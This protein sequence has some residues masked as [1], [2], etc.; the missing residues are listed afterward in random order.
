MEENRALLSEQEEKV[1][2]TAYFALIFA[3]LF[4]SGVFGELSKIDGGQWAWLG[5]FDFTTLGGKFGRL[6]LGGG[7]LAANF[8][9]QGG[10]GSRDAFLYA[11]TLA[12]QVIFALGVVKIVEDLGALKAAQKLI[13]PILRLVMGVP[14]SCAVALVTSLQ[15]TD[16]GASMVKSLGDNGQINEREKL[17]MTAFQY[18][19]AGTIV[20]YFS[21]G[22][23]V[24]PLLEIP[25]Y[26]PLCTI[27]I[28]KFIS[29]NLMRVIAGKLVK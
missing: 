23:A 26:I 12:P 19:G 3:I 27:F 29:G 8:R 18:A 1:G 17:I 14:G 2:I 9:G 7:T 24:M 16:A 20:N 6:G 4:F 10:A 22:A 21:I 28:C 5:A 13:T 25:I 15:S 11:V